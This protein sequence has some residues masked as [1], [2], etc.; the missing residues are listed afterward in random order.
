M[1]LLVM[2]YE[3]SEEIT[4]LGR[5]A[6]KNSTPTAADNDSGA[7]GAV[8][9]R[10][11]RGRGW[12]TAIDADVN[13]KRSFLCVAEE[14][15]L[16]SESISGSST[17]GQSPV[18]KPTPTLSGPI[19][20]RQVKVP[21]RIPHPEPSTSFGVDVQPTRM[22]DVVHRVDVQLGVDLVASADRLTNESIQARN[23][24]FVKRVIKMNIFLEY[25]GEE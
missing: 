10:S 25:H 15:A 13:R 24:G 7:C 9:R 2:K 22:P 5:K 11:C 20:T 17:S 4:K 19:K 18:P 1:L 14:R 16:A 23:E 8:A 21:T 6:L 12:G 3:K